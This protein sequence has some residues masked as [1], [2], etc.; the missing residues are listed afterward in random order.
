MYALMNHTIT[1]DDAADLIVR[2]NDV[3]DDNGRWDTDT[4]AK[5][6]DF[7]SGSFVV[8]LYRNAT[9]ENGGNGTDQYNARGNN[10]QSYFDWQYKP[11]ITFPSIPLYNAY[12]F[13]DLG[14]KNWEI[15]WDEIDWGEVIE[16]ERE[17]SEAVRAGRNNLLR[18]LQ[19]RIS[20]F[21]GAIIKKVGSNFVNLMAALYQSGQGYRTEM[22]QEFL[23][24]WEGQLIERAEELQSMIEDNKNQPNYHSQRSIDAQIAAVIEAQTKVNIMRRILDEKIQ[25]NATAATYILGDELAKSAEKDLEKAKK[26]L[27]TFGQFAV[28]VGVKAGESAADSLIA[29]VIGTSALTVGAARAFGEGIGESY[30]F[31]AS[32]EESTLYAAER[33]ATNI[34][35]NTV[36]ENMTSIFSPFKSYFSDDDVAAVITNISEWLENTTVGKIALSGLESGGEDFLEGI[37]KPILQQA[38]YDKKSIY[39]VEE[40]VRSALISMVSEIMNSI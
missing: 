17:R 31:G 12:E 2:Q 3:A 18:S 21:F 25:E 8:E 29:A 24:I 6:D 10:D 1:E 16:A 14:P 39:D 36:K 11:V 32:Y 34:A 19:E 35:L 22:N 23:S 40:G 38:T 4:E 20:S 15:N 26:D 9:A 13:S 5:Q 30:N 33:A 27:G 37:L 7:P 28:D